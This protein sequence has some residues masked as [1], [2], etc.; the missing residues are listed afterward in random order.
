L[1]PGWCFT[2][3]LLYSKRLHDHGVSAQAVTSVRCLALIMFAAGV[4]TYQGRLEG[5]D[6]LGGAVTLSMAATVLIPLPR[7]RATSPTGW[8]AEQPAGFAVAAEIERPLADRQDS[9]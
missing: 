4:E 3:S 2:I 5:I 6:E 1:V 8:R 7:S 9:D